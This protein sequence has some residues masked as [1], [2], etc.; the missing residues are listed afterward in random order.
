MVHTTLTFVSTNLKYIQKKRDEFC[1]NKILFMKKRHEKTESICQQ[2]VNKAIAIV[3]A[4]YTQT[5]KRVTSCRF[6]YHP[7]CKNL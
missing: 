2:R 4:L 7:V 1:L 3:Q 6:E 5:T